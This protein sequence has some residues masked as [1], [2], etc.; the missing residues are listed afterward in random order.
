MRQDFQEE[1]PR[2]RLPKSWRA[3]IK[4]KEQALDGIQERAEDLQGAAGSLQ[5]VEMAGMAAMKGEQEVDNDGAS[6]MLQLN[7]DVQ[8]LRKQMIK[9]IIENKYSQ[10]SKVETPLM[11][12]SV[13]DWIVFLAIVFSV[14]ILWRTKL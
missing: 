5:E 9:K 14:V 12:K 11:W 6:K 8:E 7:D 10:K 1:I 3:K 4:R 2:R 13:R